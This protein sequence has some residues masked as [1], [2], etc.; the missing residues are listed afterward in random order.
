MKILS[1]ADTIA[2]CRN[3][4]IA[5]FGD[6]ELRLAG[7]GSCSS[8]RADPRL[9]EELKRLLKKSGDTLVAIPN[10]PATPRRDVWDKYSARPYSAMYRQPLYGS[11]FITRPDSAPWIDTPEY[12][13]SVRAL[14]ADKVVTLVAGDEKSLTPVLLSHAKGVRVVAGPRQ[15]AY[16]EIDKIEA[17]ILDDPG[18]LVLLCLGATA[19][20]LAARLDARR[21][22]ALDL[23]HIGMF[24]RHAGAYSSQPAELASDAYRKQLREKHR[25]GK[26]GGDGHSHA[27]AVRTF[28]QQ[29]NGRTVLD[30]GCG[31]GTL[32]NALAGTKVFEYDPGI[33]GKDAL[34]KPADVVACTD[35][36]EHIEPESLDAVLR[37]IYH[38]AAKGAYLVISTR[39]ARELLPDGR[40]AHLIV[41]P[42]EWW[43]AELKKYG[44]QS[45][46]SAEQKGLCVWLTK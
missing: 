17:Q 46:Q 25:D 6:G 16:T 30:Y 9:A 37:H 39:P 23:G 10:F 44:W 1:E 14:W 24:M 40:N 33:K 20:V 22:H 38:L 42:P 4:S 41:K 3:H 28:L 34:P 2:A 5:R 7:G 12:W 11:A 18:E 32:A 19:T 35:V 15:H 43:L 31:R 36:L 13:A 27:G 21:I 8:Q 45:V 26:W 29:L